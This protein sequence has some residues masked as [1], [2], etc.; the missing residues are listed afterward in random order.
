MTF[1]DL[2]QPRFDF[3]DTRTRTRLWVEWQRRR[4]HP[5]Y[6]HAVD[7]CLQEMAAHLST[8]P[9]TT[10]VEDRERGQ[11]LQDIMMLNDFLRQHPCPSPG[12][13]NRYTLGVHSQALTRLCQPELRT[14]FPP[15][16]QFAHAW[17]I[18]LPLDPAILAL[19]AWVAATVF[20][21]DYNIT[22]THRLVW[23]DLSLWPQNDKEL[24]VEFRIR[25]GASHDVLREQFD[26]VL[27][28]HA[29]WTRPHSY[30]IRDD[31]D[32]YK[33]VFT[34]YD[35][36]AQGYSFSA[37]AQQLWPHEWNGQSENP[38]SHKALRQRARGYVKRAHVLIHGEAEIDQGLISSLG[39]P[40]DPA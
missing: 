8:L 23:E 13:I 9:L 30:R 28:T 40:H 14:L 38:P 39:R 10:S 24:I 1:D 4:R 31:Q 26:S 20:P 21:R 33:K 11:T 2:P 18:R 16:A 36:R 15:L 6:P 25:E 37:L 12:E 17:M 5:E 35:L 22:L 32:Y 7:V 29:A 27:A 34:A 3:L 19:P